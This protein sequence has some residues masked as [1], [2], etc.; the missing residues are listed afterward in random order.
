MLAV[1][2]AAFASRA[3]SGAYVQSGLNFLLCIPGGHDDLP[4]ASADPVMADLPCGEDATR[5]S[6]P[7]ALRPHGAHAHCG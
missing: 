6:R 5:S 3:A 4:Y 1:G 7:R 2:V